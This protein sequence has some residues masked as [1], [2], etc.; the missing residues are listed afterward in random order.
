MTIDAGRGV[1]KRAVAWGFAA[2]ASLACVGAALGGTV[3]LKPTALVE[4]G[5]IVRVVDVCAIDDAPES[6]GGVVLIEDVAAARGD[7]AWLTIGVERVRE[8]LA[9]AGYGPGRIGVSGSACVVRFSGGGAPSGEAQPKAD[10]SERR[11]PEV[12]DLSGP[13]SVRTRVVELLE[14]VYGVGDPARLRLLF[15]DADQALLSMEEWGRRVVVRPGTSGAG[16]RALVDV[17]VFAGEKM[18][19]SGLLRVDVEVLRRVVVVAQDMERGERVTGSMV[20]EVDMWVSPR[21]EA[22]PADVEEVLG[23][24]ARRPLRSGEVLRGTDL[25]AAIV[26]QR[27]A[28]VTVMCLKGGIGVQARGRAMEDGRE[29]DVIECRLMDSDTSFEARVDGAGR[30][31]VVLD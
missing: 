6:I 3:K 12:V 2:C 29:G 28:L 21:G 11:T 26:V 19:A 8:A 10:P 17:R 5:A 22:G 20:R 18:V 23:L 13:A 24:R 7:G 1:W 15:D 25:E 4:R 30:V 16:A 9:E 27:G 31:V 14:R